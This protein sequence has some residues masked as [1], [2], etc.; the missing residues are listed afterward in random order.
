MVSKYYVDKSQNHKRCGR[1]GA[2]SSKYLGENWSCFGRTVCYPYSKGS[3]C[4]MSHATQILFMCNYRWSKITQQLTRCKISDHP[5]QANQYK[6][7]RGVYFK[8]IFPSTDK[9]LVTSSNNRI[10][11]TQ[12]HYND[13]IMSAM[14]SQITGDSIVC[15]TVGSGADRRKHQSSA[16]LA[17]VRG[18]NRWSMNSPHKRPVTRKM[19]PF[20]DAQHKSE[21]KTL[22]F[23]IKL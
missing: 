6:S 4:K 7:I 20:D 21:P 10:Q 12:I 5:T 2:C 1:Y 16:S 18:I 19:V 14:A 11:H 17:C 23:M 15:S 13:G 3:T 8:Y 22:L 9:R